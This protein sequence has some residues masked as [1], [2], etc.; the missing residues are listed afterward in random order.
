MLSSLNSLLLEQGPYLLEDTGI[1]ISDTVDINV[2][3]AVF[4]QN[5]A[6]IV[7]AGLDLYVGQLVNQAILTIN[8]SGLRNAVATTGTTNN[9]T[10]LL[11][12]LTKWYNWFLY[13]MPLFFVIN[14]EG[15]G[16]TF[17]NIVE[18]KIYYVLTVIDL[19][20]FTMSATDDVPLMFEITATSSSNNSI[21]CVSTQGL[22]IM[23]HYIYRYYFW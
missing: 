19:E 12:R 14:P 9:V 11:T 4:A 20:T 17:G 8:Y 13:K 18:N 15:N 23:V 10:V 1:T 3:G 7:S 2:F 5:T 22:T 21:T 16:K 6:T